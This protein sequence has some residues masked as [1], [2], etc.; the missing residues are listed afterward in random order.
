MSAAAAAAA[1]DAAAAALRNRTTRHFTFHNFNTSCRQHVNGHLL[2]GL[3]DGDW[4]QVDVAVAQL[5]PPLPVKVTHV[6]FCQFSQRPR[7]PSRCLC[8]HFALF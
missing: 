5:L 7:H 4:L 6:L 3:G 2:L 8:F 1:A